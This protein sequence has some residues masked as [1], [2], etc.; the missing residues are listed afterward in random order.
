MG[1]PSSPAPSVVTAV[2]QRPGSV[3]RANNHLPRAF[4]ASSSPV[5]PKL[6]RLKRRDHREL[7]RG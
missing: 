6:A 4:L 5:G 1:G 3:P 2:Q 7:P